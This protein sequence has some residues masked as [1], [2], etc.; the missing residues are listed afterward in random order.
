MNFFCITTAKDKDF[1]L[2]HLDLNV[3]LLAAAAL[4][5]D[6]ELAG[7]NLARLPAAWVL[8]LASK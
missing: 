6:R 5:C 8:S 3:T 1:F 4:L 7:S 2:S